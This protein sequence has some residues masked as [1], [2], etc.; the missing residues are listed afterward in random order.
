MGDSPFLLF[1]VDRAWIARANKKASRKNPG[2]SDRDLVQAPSVAGASICKTT[3]SCRSAQHTKPLR[4]AGWRSTALG[5]KGLVLQ[6]CSWCHHPSLDLVMSMRK[7]PIGL[8][9]QIRQQ[10]GHGLPS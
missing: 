4:P 8:E 10:M 7:P 9:A 3:Q 6:L 5:L 2:G 1:R